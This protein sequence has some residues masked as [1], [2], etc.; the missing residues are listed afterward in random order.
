MKNLEKVVSKIESELDEKDAIREVALKSSRVVVRLSGSIL[1][2]LHKGE[3]V[4]ESLQEL[5]DEVSRLSGLVGDH[6]DIALAGYVE[7]ALQEYAEASILL[8]LIEKDDLPAPEDIGV[9]SIPYLLG[10]ADCV[11]ELRRLCLDSL[12]AGD[13]SRANHFLDRMEDIF[14]ALMRFDYPDAIVAIRRKQD[15]A[16]S[17]LE[18]T[19]GEVAVAASAMSLHKKMD[20]VLKRT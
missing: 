4:K 6:P 17:L 19:R 7:A 16:R 12:K 11:G 5:R 15:V 9:G 14:T 8:D 3:D 20:E 13:V 2:R 10:L 18:K 1:R